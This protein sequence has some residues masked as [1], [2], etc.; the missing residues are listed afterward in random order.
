MFGE[1]WIAHM[2]LGSSGTSSMG[3]TFR[4]HTL[5]SEQGIEVELE[6]HRRVVSMFQ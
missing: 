5:G 3:Q 4:F 6:E 2:S 1:I